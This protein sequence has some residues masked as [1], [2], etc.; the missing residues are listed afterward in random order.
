MTH[1]D[2][3]INWILL[4]FLLVSLFLGKIPKTYQGKFWDFLRANYHKHIF[5]GAL[6]GMVLSLTF[7]GVDE[8]VQLFLTAFTAGALG[9]LWEWAWGAFNGTKPDYNDVY[10]TVGAALIAVIAHM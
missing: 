10:Y 1:T 5:V 3:V 9:T 4:L 7:S 2:I 6:Y 8:G